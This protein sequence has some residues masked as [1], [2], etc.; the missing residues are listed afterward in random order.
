MGCVPSNVLIKWS[1]AN[2]Y[3]RRS[4]FSC[5]RTLYKNC[6]FNISSCAHMCYP[7]H[8]DVIV[9]Y[10][11]DE[12][13]LLKSSAEACTRDDMILRITSHHVSIPP[14]HNDTTAKVNIWT[15]RLLSAEGVRSIRLS[16]D[17]CQVFSVAC[18]ACG[19]CLLALSLIGWTSNWP[20]SIY[21]NRGCACS[22]RQLLLR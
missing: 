16:T 18:I 6:W 17:P 21:L 12:T 15:K 13:D 10:I 22:A 4:H 2:E 1:N 14:N 7:M 20:Y 8:V 5:L 3:F 19:S 11:Q 9:K